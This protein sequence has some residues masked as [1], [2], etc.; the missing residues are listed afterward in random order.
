MN[1]SKFAMFEVSD[2]RSVPNANKAPTI[3]LWANQNGA[4]MRKR[5]FIRVVEVCSRARLPNEL[6]A[7]AKADAM[8]CHVTTERQANRIR[9]AP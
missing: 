8:P 3:K 1:F 5:P 9:D 7:N 4:P 2:T 6:P